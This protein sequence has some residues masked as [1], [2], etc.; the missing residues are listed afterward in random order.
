MVL[1]FIKAPTSTL[2]SHSPFFPRIL[3][4]SNIALNYYKTTN[5]SKSLLAT[6]ELNVRNNQFLEDFT[7]NRRAKLSK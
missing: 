2:S 7:C 6:D 4:F 5:Y 1:F 3:T